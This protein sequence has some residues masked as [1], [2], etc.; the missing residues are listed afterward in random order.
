MLLGYVQP[1]NALLGNVSIVGCPPPGSA[2]GLHTCEGC[3]LTAWRR[4]QV[5]CGFNHSSAV[6]EMSEEAAALVAAEAE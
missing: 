4:S 3:H 6:V 2:S 1:I 5:S